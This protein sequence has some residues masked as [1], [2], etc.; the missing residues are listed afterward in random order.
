MLCKRIIPCLDVKDGRTV[1]GINFLELKDAGD[2]VELAAKYAADGAD[3][4]VFLDISATLDKRK[5]LAELVRKVACAINIPFTV[6]G[7]ITTAEDVKILLDSGADK[8]SLN[9]AAVKKPELIS[10]LS[11]KF[12]AQCIVVAVDCRLQNDN[13][14]VAINAGT[15]I[16][17]KLVFNWVREVENLGAGE[18]LVT[19]ME[20]D[21]TKKGFAIG[22]MQ[23][24]SKITSIPLIASG[25]A[26]SKE[27]FYELYSETSINAALGASVFHFNEIEIGELKKE[28]E[29]KGVHVR[30]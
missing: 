30:N 22:L 18:L 15:K 2:P 8:I 23:D 6:G 21:G 17:E 25:G 12:G 24:I 14:Y 28:L 10:E 29:E 4:L 7:G 16:T 19:S 9:S 20:H 11:E 3:E 1:K 13:W 27:D 26:G 5:T